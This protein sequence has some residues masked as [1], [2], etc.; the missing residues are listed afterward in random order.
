ME[1]LQAAWA[2]IADLT[3]G[4][5]SLIVITNALTQ[6]IKGALP[7]DHRWV[8]YPVGVILALIGLGFT[9]EAVLTG[10]VVGYLAT[11][12]YNAVRK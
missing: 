1:I 11:G 3:V 5:I 4:G 12:V 8:P 10:I 2:N 9:W 6:A 7:V